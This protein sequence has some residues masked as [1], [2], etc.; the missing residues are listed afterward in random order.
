MRIDIDMFDLR[1]D[2]PK[3]KIAHYI[4]LEEDHFIYHFEA[5]VDV[6]PDEDEG[7]FKIR[8]NC[9]SYYHG[10]FLRQFLSAVDMSY[11]SRGPEDQYDY[12]GVELSVSGMASRIIIKIET[13]GKAN[14]INDIALKYLLKKPLE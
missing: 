2:R 12:W 1:I 3:E 14:I 11:Y 13:Q 4:I 8:E 5:I 7:E 9:L 6:H 10:C